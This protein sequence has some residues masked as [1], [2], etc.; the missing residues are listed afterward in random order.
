MAATTQPIDVAANHD[1]ITIFCVVDGESTPFS[2]DVSPD[3]TV[4]NLKDLIKNKTK[5]FGDIAAKEL[6]LWKVLIPVDNDKNPPIVKLDNLEDKK[7]LIPTTMLS[8]L[9]PTYPPESSIHIVI[10]RP[11]PGKLNRKSML[12]KFSKST[13]IYTH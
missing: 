8:Y 1:E 5:Q 2:I 4:G 12:R 6:I 7:K 10:H 3:D 13:L 9:Y 11:P